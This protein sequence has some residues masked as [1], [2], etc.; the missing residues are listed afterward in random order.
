MANEA[1]LA[2]LS[3]VD[4]ECIANWGANPAFVLPILMAAAAAALR[5]RRCEIEAIGGNGADF[6]VRWRG[7]PGWRQLPAA[8]PEGL[9]FAGSE[10]ALALGAIGDSAVID[11]CGLGGM[12]LSA[13]ALARR[14]ALMNPQ[15][16]IVDP[17]RVA[18]SGVAPL[19]NLA[20]LDRDATVGLIGRG[21]YSPSV[22]LF[23]REP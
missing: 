10:T 19:I 9:R 13:E 3:G 18:G 23:S 22:N 6:G 5:T 12:A 20:M 2:A 15:S 1:L 7:A 14:D 21:V 8:A 4:A 16:G 11:F 17:E